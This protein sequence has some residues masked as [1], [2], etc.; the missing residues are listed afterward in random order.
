MATKTKIEIT[1]PAITEGLGQ[2]TFARAKDGQAL[3][4]HTMLFQTK[5][6]KRATEIQIATT[7]NT[8]EYLA[9]KY[10]YYF[11]L[12]HNQSGIWT[13]TRVGNKVILEIDASWSLDLWS[14]DIAGVTSVITVGSVS[15][16]AL[17]SWSLEPDPT[18]PC[19]YYLLRLTATENIASVE[20]NTNFYGN[21]PALTVDTRL[22]R[23]S[24]IRFLR[25]NNVNSF[26][27]G[28][29][30]SVGYLHVGKVIADNV[31]I[32]IA[33]NRVGG[34][35]VNFVVNFPNQLPSSHDLALQYSLDNVN[36]FTENTITGQE[37]GDYTLYIKDSLGCVVSVPYTVDERE[38]A[39]PILYISK[40]NSITFS[41]DEVWDGQSVM[42][43]DNNTLSETSLSRINYKENILFQRADKTS[44]QIKS[45]FQVVEAFVEED[46]DEAPIA[47]TVNKK[48]NNINRFL[49][50]D[51]YMYKY[52]QGYAG[53]YFIS[54]NTYLA[55][56]SVD[57][58]Y[59]L[60]GNLPD[61]AIIG[62]FVDVI[63]GG[64]SIGFFEIQ[65]VIYDPEINR[66]AII[67]KY[68]FEEAPASVIVKSNYNLLDIEV[69]EFEIDFSLLT[70]DNCRIR[71]KGTDTVFGEQNQ[72]SDNIYVKTIHDNTMSVLYYGEDN[73]D[74]FYAYGIKHF[75]RLEFSDIT[76]LIEDKISISKGDNSSSVNSSEL[77]DGNKIEFESMTRDL[78]LKACIALSSP[79]LFINN[80]GYVKKESL[81]YENIKGTNLYNLS[82][83]LIK[84]QFRKE[85]YS[86][87]P[88]GV[89]PT[90]YIPGVLTGDTG[91][92]KL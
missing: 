84:T 61:F 14:T 51:G 82:V 16:F 90:I 76:A 70:A 52:K 5:P 8:G 49:G 81:S 28:L 63:V 41:K 85:S 42:K 64:I 34:S 33:N 53:L 78:F 60:N 21:T 13:I 19:N 17:S 11:Q 47:L 10:A 26:K 6:R 23:L 50:I 59:V 22:N 67:F 39:E 86:V 92:F 4:F 12:D 32:T 24:N 35:T 58:Q 57:T 40:N 65:D 18:D 45:N 89:S 54:G 1:F 20:Y 36:Y 75:I 25:M 2:T 72:Y 66:R 31:D 80:V 37:L 74:I 38:G 46:C 29:T 79:Y 62:Q 83:E 68:T 77:Y 30:D 91:L 27:V 55:D 48:S 56:D 71:I 43:N 69:Y 7:S 87:N 88:S 44:I 3:I 15:N 9:E 73:R